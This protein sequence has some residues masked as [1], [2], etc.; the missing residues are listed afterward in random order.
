MSA[1]PSEVGS[2]L[3]D[4]LQWLLLLLGY[5][6][7]TVCLFEQVTPIKCDDLAG[8]FPAELPRLCRAR[9]VGTLIPGDLNARLQIE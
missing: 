8:I 4:Q 1:G 5:I 3:F 9:L 6:K 2:K 7:G